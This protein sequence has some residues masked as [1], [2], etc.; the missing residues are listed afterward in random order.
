MPIST[1]ARDDNPR[2]LT[3]SEIATM[4]GTSERYARRLVDERR[5]PTVKLGRLVRVRESDLLDYISANMRP[6][7]KDVR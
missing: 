3:L 1:P 5:L 6:A 7:N 2:L 4:C